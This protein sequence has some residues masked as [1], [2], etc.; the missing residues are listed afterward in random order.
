MSL[1]LTKL[2]REL[3]IEVS[4]NLRPH[5]LLQLTLTCK[6]LQFLQSILWTTIELH[7]PEYHYLDRDVYQPRYNVMPRHVDSLERDGMKLSLN[8]APKHGALFPVQQSLSFHTW[9]ELSAYVRDLCFSVMPEQKGVFELVRHFVNLEKLNINEFE[10]WLLWKPWQ[11]ELTDIE[12][13]GETP[14]FT[15]MKSLR[16]RGYLPA[17]AIRKILR[18]VS[19][20]LVHLDLGVMER[21][22][23]K[24]F[25]LIG[26]HLSTKPLTMLCSARR[27]AFFHG[28]A[29]VIVPV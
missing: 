9:V 24:L 11:T 13:H 3:L 16:L 23:P 7:P 4:S 2:P 27:T 20:D 29:G 17:T 14:I 26:L 18:S 19:R 8:G 22:H 1:V 12:L 10:N 25:L 15:K 21:H 5:D 28:L 6:K